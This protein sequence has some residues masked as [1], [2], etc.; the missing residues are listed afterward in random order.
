MN[1]VH[2][3]GGMHG[4]GS[5]DTDEDTPF[6]HDWEPTF[7]ATKKV[8]GVH[9][10]FS[11]DERR[12]SRE[13][14]DPVV[15]LSAGY[16]EQRVLALE[17]LLVDRG[18]LDEGEVDERAEGIGDELPRREDPELAAKAAEKVRMDSSFARDPESE[19][20][21]PRDEVVVR[22]M[23]PEGHTRCPRYVRGASGVVVESHGTQ[24]F[25]DASAEGE[26]V[27][28]PLYGVEFTARELWG[29]DH[30]ESDTLVLEL[31]ERYLREPEPDDR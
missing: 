22:T 19:Q 28:V 26:D 25:P 30:P 20:F 31:W 24:R 21:E 11:M 23:H 5:V 1:G 8:L 17:D 7:N 3:M 15:Y 13:R 6:V 9:G 14:L 10:V 18:V 29:E 4:F 27:G 12:Y 16:Y 2:D